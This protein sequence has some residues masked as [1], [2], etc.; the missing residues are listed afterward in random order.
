MQESVTHEHEPTALYRPVQPDERIFA[1]DALRGFALF[2]V[3]IAYTMWSLGNASPESFTSSERVINEV[4][5]ALVSGKFLTLFAFLF[6]LGFSIQ[7]FRA[8][9]RNVSVVPIYVR[10][11]LVLIAFGLLHALFLRSGDILV[12]Y[13]VTGFVLLLF[14]NA[15]NRTVVIAAVSSF[16]VPLLLSLVR[17]WIGLEFSPMP[18]A[19]GMG[20]IAKNYALMKFFYPRLLYSGWAA[21][22]GLFLFGLYIGRKRIFEN[23]G[24][25]RRLLWTVLVAGLLIGAPL[26]F[27]FAPFQKF[28]AAVTGETS[29]L[30]MRTVGIVF[31]NLHAIGL[32]SFYASSIL[33]LLQGPAW[34]RLFSPLA[35]VGRMAFTNYLLQAIIIVP[36]CLYFGLFDTFTPT[37]SLLLATGVFAFHVPF[38]ILWLKF[39]NLGPFE[40]VWRAFTYGSFP[41]MMKGVDTRALPVVA[42][43]VALPE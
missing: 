11:L 27:A 7:V 1:L 12:N 32:A 34:R 41:R 2:G 20:R 35:A 30:L 15:S 10:R 38:S 28:S 18:D 21:Y 39:F 8:E 4:L 40:W 14:R 23:V 36:I 3:L 9:R 33:L 24:E 43:P 19:T 31:S 25:N 29:K 17:P 37:T 22:L 5:L 42:T 16:F 26:H 6:G 13:A